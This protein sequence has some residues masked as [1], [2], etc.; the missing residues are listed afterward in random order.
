[1]EKKFFNV[2]SVILVVMCLSFANAS[3]SQNNPTTWQEQLDDL[4]NKSGIDSVSDYYYLNLINYTYKGVIKSEFNK[5]EIIDSL[6]SYN[7]PVV[8]NLPPVIIRDTTYKGDTCV[9]QEKA[10]PKFEI[11][12]IRKVLEVAESMGKENPI[13]EVRKRLRDL[14]KVGFEYLELEW[15]YKEDKFKSICIVSDEHGGVVYEP[16][17]LNIYTVFSTSYIVE[18]P[19]NPDKPD[20]KNL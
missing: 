5:S 2:V 17:S 16:I 18:E 20:F 13:I 14:L 11:I 3:L 19:I 7:A 4:K 9:I 6:F 10:L 12:S 8:L 1:M 15:N